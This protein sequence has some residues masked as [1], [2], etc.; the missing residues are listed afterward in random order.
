[1]SNKQWSTIVP[2]TATKDRGEIRRSGDPTRHPELGFQGVQTLYEAFRRGQTLNP[3]G[4]CLGFRAVS[5]SGFATPFIYSS[6]TEILARI[7]CFAAGLETLK[8]VPPTEDNMTLIGLYVRNCMEWF[9]AEHA[10]FCVAGAT[11]PFYDTLG[12]ESV[13]FILEQTGTKTVVASRSELERL[14]KVKKSGQCPHFE[15]VVLVDGVVPEADAMAK[16]AG[17]TVMSF[18]KVEAIGAQTIATTGHEH[19][20]P[21]PKD[22]FTF[23]YTSGTTGNPKGAI[24]THE[25]IVSA[26]AGAMSAALPLTAAD[27][28]LS[29]LPLAHI[30]ERIV[31]CQIYVNGASIAFYRGD[32]LLLI[33]DMQAC[34]PTILPAA[35]RVLNKIY[36]KVRRRRLLGVSQSTQVELYLYVVPSATDISL[37]SNIYPDSNR[38]Q[39]RGRIQKE[40]L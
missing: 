34:R 6:Y 16:E 33:D 31:Q 1:M 22:M 7:D 13:G 32:P 37:N 2:N 27:R 19:R 21:S 26:M 5:T 36:D 20:P 12:P 15:Y 23:C 40:T 4:P 17:L 24:L 39:R 14:C 3:L 25:N 28:H 35:P 38:H 18:A 8:L 9:I 29:Y 10:I 30:F 11:V